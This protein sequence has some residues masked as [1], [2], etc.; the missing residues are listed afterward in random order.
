MK[1]AVSVLISSLLSTYMA[2][3][4]EDKQL[5]NHI[6]QSRVEV[7]AGSK[8]ATSISSRYFFAPQAHS[9]VWDDFGY[10]DTDSSI[11][12]NYH[13]FDADNSFSV[14]GEAFIDNWFVTAGI[15]DVGDPEDGYNLG[16]G[17]LYDDKLKLSVRFNQGDN[18]RNSTWFKAEYNHELSGTDYI[19]TSLEVDDELDVWALSTRYFTHLGG[20]QYLSLDLGHT[21]IDTDRQSESVTS[22]LVNYYFNRNFA[23]G[24][25]VVDSKLLL[26]TKFFIDDSYHV[27]VGYQDLDR[28]E[29]YNLSF[30]AQY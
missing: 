7:G 5:F 16:F 24:A 17:Y 18:V 6:S 25:G 30:T 23:L 9:G 19:G 12:V 26:E 10:L 2:H 21:E 29:V 20:E 15:T 1:K 14:A 22:G 4:S 11:A 3:A 8:N 28:G 13:D 27:R